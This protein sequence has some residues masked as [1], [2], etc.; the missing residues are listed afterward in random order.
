M[1]C[2]GELLVIDLKGYNDG[3]NV[4]LEEFWVGSREKTVGKH[5]LVNRFRVTGT[6]IFPNHV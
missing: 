1:Q 6:L 4:F 3:V 2:V 5:R